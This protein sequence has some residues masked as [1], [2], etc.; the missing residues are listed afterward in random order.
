M[1]QLELIFVFRLHCL[2]TSTSS[3]DHFPSHSSLRHELCIGLFRCRPY[4]ELTFDPR[5]SLI[6][7][8]W[9]FLQ[10]YFP[11]CWWFISVMLTSDSFR[12]YTAWC[13]LALP[14]CLHNNLIDIDVTNK[15]YC[16]VLYSTKVFIDKTSR[17]RKFVNKI[18]W[19]NVADDE[20]RRPPDEGE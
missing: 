1:G 11:V 3:S 18:H 2:V 15:S 7:C 14:L 20:L 4:S 16:V 12:A 10:V 19:R 6:F 17:F 9:C 5:I 13:D 8:D